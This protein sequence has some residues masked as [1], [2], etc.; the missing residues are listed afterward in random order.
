MHCAIRNRMLFADLD[1][2]SVSFLLEAVSNK[3]YQTGEF[4]YRQGEPSAA[5][6]SV[7]KG[8][9]KLSMLSRDGDT[10]IVRLLGPGAAFGLEA[11][12]DQA[13]HH[14]AEPIS[15][16]DLC[17]IP[18][19][20]MNQI[21]RQQ[22]QIHQRLME[23]WQRHIDLADNHLLNLST[24]SIKDRVIRLLSLLD[25]ICKRGNTPLLLPANQDCAAMTGARIETVSRIMAELKRA[26]ALR[27]GKDGEWQFHPKTEQDKHTGPKPD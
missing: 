21:A 8:L 13:Y 22:P 26:D 20:T 17:R 25:D 3:T 10:R 16:V 2:Q 12:L 11:L 6:F 9:V 14:T 24:G 27:R 5:L 19:T 18:A 4:V 1:L 15:E 7:R 23:Q